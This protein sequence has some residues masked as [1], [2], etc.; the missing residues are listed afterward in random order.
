[1]IFVLKLKAV[2]SVID[3]TLRIEEIEAL[4]KN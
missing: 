4:G 3:L 2:L 1:M